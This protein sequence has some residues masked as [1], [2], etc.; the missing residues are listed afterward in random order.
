MNQKFAQFLKDND[1][2]EIYLTGYLITIVHKD[3]RKATL[4]LSV[5]GA[6]LNE[7]YIAEKMEKETNAS[8]LD[9]TR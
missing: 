1:V 5:I 8:N 2:V 3:G 6:M 9:A 7:L 4:A